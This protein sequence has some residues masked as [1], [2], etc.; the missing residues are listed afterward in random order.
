MRKPLFLIVTAM[1]LL[2]SC[3]TERPAAENPLLGEWDTPFGVPPFDKIEVSHYKPAFQVAMAEHLAEVDSIVANPAEP[4]FENVI[5]ALD[6]CG[7]RL[8]RVSTVFSMVGSADTNAEMQAVQMEMSPVL[9]QHYD[10]VSMNE[11]L[12]EKVSAVYEKRA[13][14]GLD[15]LQMRLLEKTYNRYVRAGAAL[16]ADKKAE[17]SKINEELSL[18]GVRFGNNLL[19]ENKNFTLELSG[20]E[21]SGL[22]QSV[23]NAAREEADKRGIPGKYVFTLSKPSLLPF[24]TYSDR[25]DLREKLYRGYLDRGN[26]GNETDNKQI[27]ND[28][29]RLRTEK[30]RLLGYDSHADF[31]LSNVMAKTPE[32]VYGLLDDLWTPALDRAKAELAEMK[33]LKLAETGDESFESWDWWYYA[34][35]VRKQKYDLDEEALRPYFSL[36]NVRSGIFELSNRLYGVTF[37]PVVAPVYNEECQVYEVLDSDNSHLGVL[38]LDFHP[39]DGKGG[40]AWCGRFR[41]QRFIDGKRISPVVS[42]VCNFTRP[43]GSVP[44]LLTLDETETFFHEFGHALHSLFSQV[45]YQ[46]LSGVERDFV[47]LPSQIMENWAFEPQMLKSYALHYRS[48]EPIPDALVEKIKNS[49]LFNQGFATVEYLA[50]SYSDMD[51]HTLEQFEPLDV[52]AFENRK[53]NVERGLI[54]E[55]APRYRY[56]YFS[57]IF[58]GGYSAGYYSYIWAEVLD[59]DAFQAFVETGDIFNRQVA[60]RFRTL[61]SRGGTSDGMVLYEQFRGAQPDR[62]P[63][64]RARGLVE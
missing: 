6:N 60:E 32:N 10:K 57:H 31:V 46:G 5:L 36:E 18:L 24:L 37:R 28:I 63:L 3:S 59:K 34:E 17:L 30:A 61:L 21:L 56:P 55:I 35:K 42:I 27:I 23:K 4:D 33:A 53:L 54:P 50:A 26:Y 13:S 25:R 43:I 38:Y 47:E 62:K 8:K 52:N 20:E 15:S 1:S 14:L 40:G 22:P 44:A 9:S 12:F 58:D 19:A 2:C 51:I 41:G 16:P 7:E 45:P 49:A 48:N 39:R 11:K 29:V 64:L